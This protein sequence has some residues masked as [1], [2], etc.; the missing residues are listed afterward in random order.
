MFKSPALLPFRPFLIFAVLVLIGLML[1]APARLLAQVMDNF[2][3]ERDRIGQLLKAGKMTEALPLLEKLAAARPTDGEVMFYLGFVLYSNVTIIKDADARKRQRIRARNTLAKAKELGFNSPLLDQMLEM[4]PPDGGKD[5][6]YST[7]KEADGAMRDGEAAFVQGKLDEA[8]AAYQRALQLDPKLYEAAL[9]AGDMYY[10][11]GRHDKAEEWYTK[12]VSINP[13][14]ETAYR[15]SASPLMAQGKLEQARARYIEAVIAEPYT[16]L[17]WAGL[18]QWAQAA[19]VRLAHPRIEPKSTVS[20]MQNNQ[21]TITIDPKTLDSKGGENAWAVYGLARA[22]WRAK[23]FAEAYPN[24]KTY[25]HSLREEAD[26][27]RMVAENA[28]KQVK[29]G[30]VTTLE[31]ML[32]NLVK[33]YDEGLIEA[34]VLL[35]RPNEGIV[36]DYAEYRKANRDKL[37]RY[38][39]DYVTSGKN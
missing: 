5:D 8:L 17:S 26:A 25:R 1:C 29:E 4:I 23:R 30:K 33:L 7:N 21:M 2:A 14:R 28:K 37:R 12:A 22:A 13:D 36:Q 31:P 15:Y 24:E 20:P 16:R 32:T 9:F 35:A 10:K 3:A 34:Y 6:V 18:N 38:L 19:G 39:T 11:M 27:L